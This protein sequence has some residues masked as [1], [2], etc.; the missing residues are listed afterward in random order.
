MTGMTVDLYDRNKL[1]VQTPLTLSAQR[2]SAN[3]IGGPESALLAAQGDGL[4]TVRQWLGYYVIVR[5]RYGTPTWWGR[6]EEAYASTGGVEVGAS[7]REL[8]NRIAVLY[9]YLDGDGFPL[10]AHTAWAEHSRSRATYGRFEERH[11]LGEA[12]AAQAVAVR[13]RAL[14]AIGLPRQ[15][16]TLTWQA[17]TGATLRC[18]GLWQT[19]RQ[20]Y[21]S[22]PTGRVAFMAP[23]N[24]EQLLG[25]G[26]TA[27]D[28][29]FADKRVQRLAG[30]LEALGEGDRFTITGSL[31]NDGSYTVFN[32]AQGKPQTYT[33]ATIS[34]SPGDN[35]ADSA[36]GLGFV[37]VGYFIQV[38]GSPLNSR[39][40]LIDE[41][42]R[43]AIATDTAVT[44][45]ISAEVAG[46]SITIRQGQA[47]EVE[48]E[49]VATAPGSSV[50]LTTHGVK[51]AYSFSLS[52]ALGWSAGEVWVKLRR[53]GAPS[54]SVKV[55]L[56]TTSG[57]QPGAVLATA[58]LTG[59]TLLPRMSWV[60]FPLATAVPLT[61]GVTYW[62]VISRTGV[63]SP[64]DYYTVG[65]DEEVSHAGT[66]RLWTGS[67]WVARP[68]AAALPFQIWGHQA[69]MAQ[70]RE[71]LAVAGQYFSGS[72]VRANAGILRRQYRDG[73]LSALDELSDLLAAGTSSG[74][75]LL[76]TVTPQWR[77]VIEALPYPTPFYTLRHDRTL[78]YR[79]GTAVEEG[80]LPVGQWC[81]VDGVVSQADALAPLSPFVIGFLE[82]NAERHE[83]SDLRALDATDIW[84]IGE[85]RQG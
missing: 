56:C 69:T 33:A 3:A 4:D 19:L 48:G 9:T 74:E 34:F 52:E 51:V 10:P 14:A 47:L 44:G 11:T 64:T 60:Q 31:A 30:G 2:Y 43:N 57:G 16:L 83:I 25:W 77:V 21:Y 85:V 82:Y 42:G 13:D 84:A 72:D 29:G 38:E 53:V 5:N 1:P 46:P 27:T 62:L 79:S 78:A 63:N 23:D 55:E 76:P 32:V 61:P 39:Y 75:R 41:T 37:K 70:M 22:N 67:T 8:R 17:T 18:V 65:L 45:A 35:L 49:V 59:V 24:A 15:S 50:T 28:I 12:N 71:I 80:V 7:L 20:T 68:T 36:E 54:D 58:T 66:L 73:N 6:I 26:V 81:S 40:H